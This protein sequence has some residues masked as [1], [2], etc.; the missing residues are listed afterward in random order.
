MKVFVLDLNDLTLKLQEGSAAIFPTDTLPALGICPKY[1][2]KI[3]ELKKRSRTKPL[4]LMGASAKELLGLVDSSAREDASKMAENYWPGALTMVLPSSGKEVDFLNPNSKTIG[5]RV[6]AN[7]SARKLLQQI[8]PLATT[9]ANISGRPPLL[10]PEEVYESFPNIPVLGPIP[11]PSNS[12][13]AS[14]VIE[15]DKGSWRLIRKGA[16]I[17]VIS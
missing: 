10:S 3:W 15:W 14:T 7:S 5:M 1:A 16:V 12:G 4:I 6:P 9:S 8:G 2:F 17:P 13:Q 11:W